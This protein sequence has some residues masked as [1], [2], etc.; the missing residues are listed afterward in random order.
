MKGDANFAIQEMS[1]MDGN[2]ECADCGKSE[3]DWGNLTTGTFLCKQCGSIHRT[4]GRG[5]KLKNV[6]RGKWTQEE[7][8]FMKERGNKKMNLE[9]Q[10]NIPDFMMKPT[11]SD[12]HTIKFKYISHKYGIGKEKGKESPRKRKDASKEKGD[13]TGDDT[14]SE[15]GSPSLSLA[16]PKSTITSIE[17]PR[18]RSSSSGSRIKLPSSSNKRPASRMV[19]PEE[20]KEGALEMRQGEEWVPVHVTVKKGKL[21][22]KEVEPRCEA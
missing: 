13:D 8:E 9:Y 4:L 20:I 18:A 21:Q 12:S 15:K 3:I 5:Y 1:K 2:N 11:E 6:G 17:S 22:Y 7:I 16:I 19:L 10:K 14:G